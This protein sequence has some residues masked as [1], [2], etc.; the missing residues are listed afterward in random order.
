MTRYL[1]TSIRYITAEISETWHKYSSYEREL[2]K[3]FSR[4]EV[5][6]SRSYVYTCVNAITLKT[7]IHFNGVTSRLTC[8]TSTAP[9]SLLA[10]FH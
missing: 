2:L 1:S 8:Y 10:V 5:K 9:V 6:K 4:S 3:R 7:Y